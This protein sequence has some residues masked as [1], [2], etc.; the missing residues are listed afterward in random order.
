MATY[1]K[2]AAGLRDDQ[3]ILVMMIALGAAIAGSAAYGTITD[4][5]PLPISGLDTAGFRVRRTHESAAISPW[6]ALFY[7]LNPIGE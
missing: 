5:L 7:T 3:I 6:H 4:W 2:F 1:G